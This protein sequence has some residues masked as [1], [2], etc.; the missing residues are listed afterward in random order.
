MNKKESTKQGKR[1][2]KELKEMKN[3]I[4]ADGAS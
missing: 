3:L 1:K 2:F 4:S